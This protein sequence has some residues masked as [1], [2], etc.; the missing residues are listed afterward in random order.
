[1]PQ[2]AGFFGAGGAPALADAYGTT[3]A[4]G[5]A[6]QALGFADKLAAFGAG[7]RDFGLGVLNPGGSTSAN[8][9]IQARNFN[10]TP[11]M[12]DIL[13]NIVQQLLHNE[14]SKGLGPFTGT[15][16]GFAQSLTRSAAPTWGSRPK[17]VD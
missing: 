9:I 4:Q 10:H 17:Q 3:F 15:V 13:Q 6:P 8:N 1:M 11:A 16:Q 2:S 5:A 7:A 12:G 14:L